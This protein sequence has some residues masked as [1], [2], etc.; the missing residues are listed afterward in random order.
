MDLIPFLCSFPFSESI[1]SLKD[2]IIYLQDYSISRL[3]AVPSL[4]RAILPAL[5]SMYSS[6]TQISLKLLMLSGEI[7]DMSLWKLLAKLLPQTSVLNIYGSTE[8]DFCHSDLLL[9]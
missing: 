2:S 1:T 3:V 9:S 7:F 6:T 4:I 8:V 5:Q